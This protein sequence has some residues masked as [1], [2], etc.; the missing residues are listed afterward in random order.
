[1][2]DGTW[3]LDGF[4]V[5]LWD[6]SRRNVRYGQ[7]GKI[8][9]IKGTVVRLVLEFDVFVRCFG[10]V[11]CFGLIGLMRC[12]FCRLHFGQLF[13]G[14]PKVEGKEVGITINLPQPVDQAQIINQALG[15]Q[16][17]AFA[18]RN[19]PGADPDTLYVWFHSGSPVNFGKI[20][21]PVIDKALDDGRSELDPA[22]RKVQYETFVSRMSSQITTLW[23]WYTDWFIASNDK[24]TGILGPNLPD[25]SGKP[26]KDKPAPVLVGYHQLLG[27]SKTK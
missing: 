12:R 19:Y 4:R 25:A 3:E 26:G 14:F 22:K 16:V 20:N 5:S 1:V 15:S 24:V 23:G 27:I 2:A 11:R 7:I 10:S 18:W 6:Y 17:D 9:V 13:Q 21:D 8:E